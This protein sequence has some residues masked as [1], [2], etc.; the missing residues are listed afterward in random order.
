MSCNGCR[1]LRRRC[2]D[3]CTLR[4]CLDGIDDPRAQA[5]ATLFVSKFFGRSDLMAFIAAVPEN[6]R[7]AC[8]RTVN[9]VTGA[10]GLLSTGN[11]HVCQKAVETVLVGGNLR[12]VF[13]GILTPYMNETFESFRCGGAWDIPNQFSNKS[14]SFTDG[15]DHIDTTEWVGLEKRWNTTSSI[16][17]E[18]ELSDVSLGLD[19][20]NKEPKLLNLFV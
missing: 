18:T 13:A 14:G 8:G 20:G 12:P 11:W 15:S 10:V 4:A 9:P 16:G 17:S 2:S 7:P 6:R 3:N 1:V 5:N 19:S